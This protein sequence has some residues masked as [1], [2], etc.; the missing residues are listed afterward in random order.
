MN[1]EEAKGWIDGL[2]KTMKQETSGKFPE[3][4]YKDEVYEA[5]NMGIKLLKAQPCEDAIS[6]T[7]L[8]E[9]IFITAENDYQK[10]WNDALESVYKNAPS[11]QPKTKTGRWIEEINDYGEIMRWHC[12]NCY[13][14][15]GFTTNCKY[16][17]CPYCGA[18]MGVR[19]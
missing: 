2:I 1:N 14:D 8:R 11:V 16:D 15:S 6:R 17:F 18:K 12:S 7:D 9:E 19:E 3:P 4:P 13:D 10:G 5:L